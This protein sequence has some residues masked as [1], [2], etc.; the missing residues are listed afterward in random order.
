MKENKK[1]ID[2]EYSLVIGNAIM[3]Q[4][5]T[6]FIHFKNNPADSHG[7]WIYATLV[8]LSKKKAYFVTKNRMHKIT[9][10][11]E[12]IIEIEDKWVP[13]EIANAALLGEIVSDACD[14]EK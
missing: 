10:C 14:M 6:T 7:F 12:Q 4:G 11:P 5:I 2:V 1:Y 8:R 13:E 3:S 9:L